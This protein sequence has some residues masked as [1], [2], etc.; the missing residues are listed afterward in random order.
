MSLFYLFFFDLVKSQ[1]MI[2][3]NLC[4]IILTV[5]M[6]NFKIL[7]KSIFLFILISLILFIRLLKWWRRSRRRGEYKNWQRE[8]KDEFVVG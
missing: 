3:N 1:H 6:E 7:V 2:M 5:A 4:L 8:N